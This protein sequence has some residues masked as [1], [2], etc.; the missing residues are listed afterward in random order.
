MA[1]LKPDLVFEVLGVSKGGMV[2]D[3]DVGESSKDEV[4]HQTEKP[5]GLWSESCADWLA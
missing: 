4:K 1:N 3:E 2:E 5:G